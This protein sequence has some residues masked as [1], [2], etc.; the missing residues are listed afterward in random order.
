M[1]WRQRRETPPPFSQNDIS[2]LIAVLKTAHQAGIAGI[3]VTRRGT[4]RKSSTGVLFLSPLILPNI[5]CAQ[6]FV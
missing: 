3:S 2:T 5:S 6:T 4:Q 1:R